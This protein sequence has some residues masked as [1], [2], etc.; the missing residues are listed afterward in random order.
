MRQ[1]LRRLL[2]ACA[3]VTVMS[4][5]AFAA[6][7]ELKASHQWN[8]KDV[9]HKMVQII[10]DEVAKA[11]VGVSVRVYPAKSLFKPKEQWA[12]LTKGPA[13]YLRLSAG[14]CREPP[15]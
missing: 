12:P 5:A 2:S 14:L 4:S 11:D 1:T 10:A 8:T 13:R 9:R 7:V 3:C 6:D 15:S